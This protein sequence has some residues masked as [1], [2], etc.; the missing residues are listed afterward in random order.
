MERREM[1]VSGCR[2]L[3]LA[4]PVMLATTAGLALALGRVAGTQPGPRAACF[5]EA[6]AKPPERT[7]KPLD[8]ED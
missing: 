6:A 1:L 7:P 8:E 3:A 4:W 5:P 2:R